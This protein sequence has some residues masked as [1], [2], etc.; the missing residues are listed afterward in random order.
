MEL[1]Q[2]RLAAEEQEKE[3]RHELR[4]Q[5]FEVVKIEVDMTT[6]RQNSFRLASAIKFV[7]PFCDYVE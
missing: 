2:R 5:G 7:L 6:K 4:T 3:R 1:E